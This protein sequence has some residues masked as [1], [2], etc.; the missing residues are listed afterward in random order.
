MHEARRMAESFGVDAA[1]YDRARPGYP[2]A[3]VTRIVTGSPGPDVLD[4]GCGTGIAARQFHA[5]GCT[6][7]GVEPDARMADVARA[8]G[9][10]VE[11]ATFEAWEPH[12]RTFDAVIAAQ[13]WQWVDPVAGAEKAARLLRPRGLLGLFGHVFEPP[14]EVAEPFAAAYRRA[15]PDSPFNAQTGRRPLELYQAAYQSFAEAIRQTGQFGEPEQW[16]FDW[17]HDYTRDQWLDLLPTTGGLTRLSADAT[18]G[19]LG[20]VGAAIDALG[21]RFTMNYTTLAVA[22]VRTVPS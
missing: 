22:A 9:V 3:L 8:G 1:R 11:V 20:A 21:G 5:A 4:V 15:V 16:R 10:P 14:A 17:E 18:T 12:E 13:S 7:L 19:I 6:V 2:N